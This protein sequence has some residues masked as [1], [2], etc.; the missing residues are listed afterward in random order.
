MPSAF[1]MFASAPPASAGSAAAAPGATD[2]ETAS[3]FS[4]NLADA[5][6]G[7]KADAAKAEAAHRTP[8]RLSLPV[9]SSPEME[10]AETSDASPTLAEAVDVAPDALIAGE[11]PTSDAAADTEQTDTPV[12]PSDL[13]AAPQPPLPQSAPVAAP[14]VAPT[15]ASE[16]SLETAAAED[17]SVG[18]TTAALEQGAA[19]GVTVEP[20]AQQ[21]ATA[22]TETA[23]VEAGPAPPPIPD[24]PGQTPINGSAETSAHE[25]SLAQNHE[26][27]AA[28]PVAPDVDQTL[29]A[30]A[31]QQVHAAE[32]SPPVAED[33]M[34]TKAPLPESG[35]TE[36]G[37]AGVKNASP[38]ASDKSAVAA[39]A[40]IVKPAEKA[41]TKPVSEPVQSAGASAASPKIETAAPKMDVK[42]SI[43]SAN[44]AAQ[45]VQT[46]AV[47][48][49]LAVGEAV[50]AIDAKVE[51]PTEPSDTGSAP[52]IA[53]SQPTESAPAKAATTP[54][55]N[56]AQPNP[57]S[58]KA[59][60]A[61]APAEASQ[62]QNVAQPALGD[63]IAMADATPPPAQN[64]ASTEA[65][66]TGTVP[67]LDAAMT[68]L[69]PAT[70][71]EGATEARALDAATTTT[72]TTSASS[73]SRATIETTA[74]L[75][76]Q[77]A[78]K[79]EGRSTRFD[80]V[81]TPEDLGRVD[82]SLEIGA[83]RRLAPR[84]AVAKTAP[85]PAFRGPAPQQPPPRN[86]ARLPRA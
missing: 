61:P 49:S 2:S 31:A 68:S 60:P 36:Q 84:Q 8:G 86:A 81:L 80:M 64:A 10:A 9:I 71:V 52:V 50:Q 75:A 21:N 83:A 51:V 30:L 16:P 17:A 72:Q 29:A 33:A 65:A 45:P 6:Q 74:H 25:Q 56:A 62:G 13:A 28:A 24:V 41:A 53:T 7:V 15:T 76:A 63:H 37:S 32:S 20:S 14:I 39:D 11:A 12:A 70:P 67:V 82:V 4:S 40:S 1:A 46:V 23:L 34:T 55:T 19:A 42:V 3:L 22:A 66:P 85:P 57:A 77:I 43:Q 26:T 44:L 73:L 27:A 78:R 18:Q 35:M 5:I 59:A 48:S 69:A 79:L 54:V 58:T 47:I 38:S